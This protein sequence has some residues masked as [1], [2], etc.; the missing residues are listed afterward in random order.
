MVV[1]LGSSYIDPILQRFI[2][3]EV[4]RKLCSLT[5][6]KDNLQCLR[7]TV[8][9]RTLLTKL[10]RYETV[11]IRLLVPKHV[12]KQ[13]PGEKICQGRR[14]AD[15]PPMVQYETPPN[16]ELRLFE[17]YRNKMRRSLESTLGPGEM[18]DEGSYHCVE[19]HPIVHST[20]QLGQVGGLC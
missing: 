20:R 11:I 8:F 4:G 10:V 9:L 17:E 5:V 3:G 19:F 15:W 16:Q 14:K 13:L 18:F 2:G 7:S 12:T 6:S 1:W